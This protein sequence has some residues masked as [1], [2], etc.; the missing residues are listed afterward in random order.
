MR[1]SS[2]SWLLLASLFAGCSHQLPQSPLGS[3]RP[4][5]LVFYKTKGF[6]HA[7]IPAGLAAFQQLGRAHNFRVD[8]TLQ[9]TR[10]VADTLRRYAAVVFLNTTGDVLD[11]TQQV[12]FERYIG[13]GHGFM[14]VHAASDTEYNWPWYGKLV[15]AYF[16]SHPQVQPATVLVTDTNHPATRFLPARWQRTDEWYN[17]RDIAPDLR[18]LATVDETSYTGGINGKQHPFAWYH[19]YGG[20]RAFYT[21]GGHLPENYAD[22]LFQR[23]LLGGLRY[24]M[25]Q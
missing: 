2:C 17:F 4:A 19:T 15:G 7:S 16:K 25:G 18:V 10:F 3:Q 5:V 14:G 23:H 24:A 1:L 13:Q 21:A 6:H 8:T 12:A 9:A 22:S 11:S 20:G